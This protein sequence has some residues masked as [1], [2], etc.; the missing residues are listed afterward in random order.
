MIYHPVTKCHCACAFAVLHAHLLLDCGR[1]KPA[2]PLDPGRKQ[3]AEQAAVQDGKELLQKKGV[4]RR[5]ACN[6]TLRIV[7]LQRKA[8]VP[9]STWYNSFACIKV[10]IFLPC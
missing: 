3:D 1:H 9:T 2:C 4:V 10:Q 7:S 6:K 8:A 5:K